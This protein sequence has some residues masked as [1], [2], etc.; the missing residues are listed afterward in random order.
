MSIF[1]FLEFLTKDPNGQALRLMTHNDLESLALAC[2]MGAYHL[3]FF[4]AACPRFVATA[5]FSPKTLISSCIPHVCGVNRNLPDTILAPSR[6]PK[7]R[8]GLKHTQTA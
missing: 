7:A 3:M 8:G 5:A 6:I 4:P 2:A 1:F